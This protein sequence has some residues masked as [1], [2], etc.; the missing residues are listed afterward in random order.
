MSTNLIKS[1]NSDIKM[2]ESVTSVDSTSI[3]SHHDVPGLKPEHFDRLSKYT[4]R[5]DPNNA[6]DK[7][8]L[9]RIMRGD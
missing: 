2:L 7:K 8:M 9:D 4:K 3:T 1:M 6:Y 5:L